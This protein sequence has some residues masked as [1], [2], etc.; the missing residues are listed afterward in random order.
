MEFTGVNTQE[1]GIDLVVEGEAVRVTDPGT[2]GGLAAAWEAKYGPDW[3][4][5]VAE[6]GFASGG[7]RPAWVFRV[8][9]VTAYGFGK[10]D[11]FSQ[12]RWTF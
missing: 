1:A 8:E 5:E 6:G 9:P 11:T 2:L 12:T 3:H 4:F 7:E 10:G